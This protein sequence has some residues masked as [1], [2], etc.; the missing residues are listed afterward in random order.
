LNFNF[1]LV[2]K[3]SIF[4]NII[5]RILLFLITCD[6]FANS[7]AGLTVTSKGYH[8]EYIISWLYTMRIMLCVSWNPAMNT[9]ILFTITWI[10]GMYPAFVVCPVS[11][12]LVGSSSQVNASVRVIR[13]Y[14]SRLRN[15]QNGFDRHIIFHSHNKQDVDLMSGNR[16]I[17][18]RIHCTYWHS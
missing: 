10:L 8:L 18:C 6:K 17:I 7:Y 2:Y 4:V 16:K 15:L 5:Q 9:M 3:Y 12:C 1:Q 14:T 13:S 11:G